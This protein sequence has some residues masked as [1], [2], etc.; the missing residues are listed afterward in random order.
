[1]NV[2]GL[3]WYVQR[4]YGWAE[5][6]YCRS[7]AVRKKILEKNH[8]TVADNLRQ[9]TDLYSRLS[10]QYFARGDHN[11]ARAVLH[12]ALNVESELHGPNHWTVANVRL[13]LAHL[14]RLDRLTP[15]QIAEVNR[16]VRLL[17]AAR[18]ERR[19]GR[20]RDALDLAGQARDLSVKW[21]GENPASLDCLTFLAELR[22]QL[23]DYPAAETLLRQAL[24]ISAR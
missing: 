20:L 7:L 2:L 5:F 13:A 3:L 23:G 18:A 4:Q 12:R 21:L 19:G 9:L 14:A 17:H 22:Q 1:M 8:P 10:A 15:A 6:Y 11:A 16:S 24:K